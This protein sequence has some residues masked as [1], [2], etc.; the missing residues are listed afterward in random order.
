MTHAIPSAEAY[1]SEPVR[2]PPLEVV[3][4]AREAAA[5]TEEYR[6]QVLNQVNTSCLRL[7]VLSGEY[8]WH[9]HPR[10]DEL[11]LVMDGTFEIELAD[12]RTLSLRPWQCVVVPAGVVTLIGPV[13]MPA[14]TL[15]RS[16]VLLVGGVKLAGVPA[17]ATAVAPR[18]FSP[19]NVTSVPAGP[20]VGA[21]SRMRAGMK[22][23]SG[24]VAVPLVVV[25]LMGAVTAAAGTWA[26]MR[27]RFVATTVV[28][29]T[30]PNFT[31][32]EPNRFR[33]VMVTLAGPE[34]SFVS[35]AANAAASNTAVS[36]SLRIIRSPVRRSIRRSNRGRPLA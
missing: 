15:A 2:F 1:A 16:V 29:V 9:Q 7:A 8:P 33:P 20:L 28:A 30:L 27:F 26:K 24:E 17:N 5:V 6:N 34:G 4:I 32:V 14:G 31:V 18:K 3:D 23:L 36:N 13:T 19:V 11:F 35:Q 25:T 22:K 21:K 12:G 10:S